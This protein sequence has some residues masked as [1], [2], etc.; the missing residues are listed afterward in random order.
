LR[1]PNG[2]RSFRLTSDP[3]RE[4]EFRV[5]VGFDTPLGRRVE[6][7]N[8]RASQ[9]AY[10]QARRGYMAAEDQIKLD[11]RQELHT[12]DELSQNLVHRRRRV[13]FTARELDLA[14]TQANP[15]QR[16]LSITSAVRGLNRAR[17]D[18]IEVWLDYE[19]T[20][21]N[22]FRDMGTMQVDDRGFW[23]DPFYRRMLEANGGPAESLPPE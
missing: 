4:S 18:L 1:I 16:G 9:I 11:V 15:G 3:P 2:G 5:G 7:N 6:R 23:L 14:E 13:Q 17:D 12:L 22:L 8:Y 10:Q 21:L 20:R 19:S